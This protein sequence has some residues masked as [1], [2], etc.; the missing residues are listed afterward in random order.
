MGQSRG[1]LRRHRNDDDDDDDDDDEEGLK[2]TV[3]GRTA[4]A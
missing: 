1:Q 4:T 2:L 3:R